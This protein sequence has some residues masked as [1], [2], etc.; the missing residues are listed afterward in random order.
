MHLR[1]WSIIIDCDDGVV[2]SI[3][4]EDV[5]QGCP[6]TKVDGICGVKY[7]EISLESFTPSFQIAWSGTDSEGTSM[8]S[9]G[10]VL[11]NYRLYSGLDFLT[12]AVKTA[13]ETYK[14]VSE[15]AVKK[16]SEFS[17]YVDEQWKEVQEDVSKKYEEVKEKAKEHVPGT[18]SL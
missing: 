6:K 15:K 1:Y 11:S 3:E 5:S 18:D 13:K 10:E 8:T 12:E 2:K 14:D 16:Y 7:S 9:I 17:E 4:F